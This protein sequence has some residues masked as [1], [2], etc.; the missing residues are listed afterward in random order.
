MSD[1]TGLTSDLS[2]PSSAL[3]IAAHPDDAEFLAG[4]TLAKWSR[5]GTVV[6][7]LVLTDG[8]KGTWDASVDQGEL[9]ERRHAE[10]LAAAAALGATGE[11]IMAGETDGELHPGVG[12][13]GR[14]ARVI[15]T[16]RPA[17]VLGHDPW[18]R[19][20]LHPD[21]HAAG[22]ICIEAVVAARDPFFHP[23][24]LADGL[25]PHRPDALLLFEADEVNHIENV[26]EEDAAAKIAA[27][28]AHTS[29]LETT[30]LY[31]VRDRDGDA[32]QNFRERERRLLGSPPVERYHLIVD[33][34]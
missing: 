24:Q 8:S 27:L 12:I 9:I 34:L 3:V 18:K 14:V 28:E 21:H 11:V 6:H 25:A 10:Q 29:Q 16:L 2:I 17:V 23:E 30:H 20:R 26:S 7:H 22:R 5:Q 4:A 1:T 31:R 19:Y 32:L 15:R 33:Q 13:R